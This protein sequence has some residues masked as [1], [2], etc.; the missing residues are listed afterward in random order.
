MNR[1]ALL[2]VAAL[3]LAPTTHAQLYGCEPS[4]AMGPM[5]PNLVTVNPMTGA[6]TVVGPLSLPLSEIVA[7]P[8]GTLL[9]SGSGGV[10]TLFSVNTTTG[11]ATPVAP[12][13]MPG[14]L[15]GMEFDAAGTLYMTHIP[16]PAGPCTLGTVNTVT[17]AFTPIGPTGTMG[18]IGGLA[19]SPT[20][21]LLLG[22]SSGGAAVT[23]PTL[24]SIN[25]ATG[26][27]TVVAPLAIGV[28]VSSLEYTSAGVL[29]AG[30]YDGVLYAINETTG[31]TT[32]I[33][34]H[35]TAVKLS[36]LA[37]LG[38]GALPLCPGT[39]EDLI[40]AYSLNLGPNIAVGGGTDV[41]ALAAGDLLQL[42]HT[43]P[44]GTF[45]GIGNVLVIGSTLPTGSA[46]PVVFPGLCIN[47]ATAFG[48]VITVGGAPATL[49]PAGLTYAFVYSGASPGT[50]M[51]IQGVVAT[52]AAANGI[53]ASTDGLELQL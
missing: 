16:S 34:P 15:N 50:S 11:L 33:G 53:F 43:S 19:F 2:L 30:G 32:P 8:T 7:T 18:P 22:V 24:F 31:M 26:M 52:G 25:T 17:G 42:T 48:V 3:C 44:G 36:G 13:S 9:G 40:T 5:G 47:L 10:S 45:I 28:P 21:G 4:M 35:L 37:D 27:A 23:P 46:F 14:G 20:S 51:M 39:G 6:T 1:L 38:S 49:G 41:L 12:I 29:V